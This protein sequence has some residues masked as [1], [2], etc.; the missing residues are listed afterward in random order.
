MSDRLKVVY[1]ITYPNGKIYVGLDLTGTATY[2]GSPS[3]SENIAA[4]LG[5]DGYRDLTVR[6]RVLWESRTATDAE[7]RAEEVRL[8][9]ERRANDPAVGYNLWPRFRPPEEDEG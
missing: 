5:P 8:I 1:E 9:R 6:K 2:F 7:A 4:D 3:Q